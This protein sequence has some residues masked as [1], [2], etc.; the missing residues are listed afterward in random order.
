MLVINID[1]IVKSAYCVYEDTDTLRYEVCKLE[2][3][4]PFVTEN[5]GNTEEKEEKLLIKI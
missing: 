2:R 5:E 3:R 1:L 4:Q